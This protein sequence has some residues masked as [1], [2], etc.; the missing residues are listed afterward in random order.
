MIPMVG[1]TEKIGGLE[2]IPGTHKKQE[3]LGKKYKERD[4]WV[5]LDENDP[6]Q[7]Q[8]KLVEAE[9]GDMILWDSRTIH[10]GHVGPG[11][12]LE[13]EKQWDGLARLSYTVC[14]TQKNR[15]TPEVL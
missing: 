15:A 11:L 5:V 3:E 2:V 4:D 12:S 10:G 9:A 1:I 7:G 13:E 14:M 8:G 6:H